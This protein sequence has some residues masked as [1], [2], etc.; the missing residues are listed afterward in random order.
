MKF[1]YCILIL[2]SFN[3]Y[4]QDM[5]LIHTSQS[6]DEFKIDEIQK[7][8]FQTAN[9]QVQSFEILDTEINLDENQTHQISFDVLPNN[10]SNKKVVWAAS[11]LN[12]VTVSE[13][14]FV[15]ALQEGITNVYGVTEDQSL[16]DSVQV[17][18]S[19]PSSVKINDATFK[20][21]PNPS[22]KILNIELM[23]NL[24][25]EVIIVD[26]QGNQIY[27][28]F[29]VKSID[30]TKFAT[31]SYLV[32]INQNNNTYSYKFIKN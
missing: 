26:M 15:T 1:I 8:S 22:D 7:I 25:Y 18:V 3:L 20:L 5:I 11:D 12:I 16:V 17:I 30:L 19:K 32:Y 31:G 27:S 29:D 14:G 21:F 24:P 28:D 4:S 10:A 13:S 23:N 6:I 2:L 9:I